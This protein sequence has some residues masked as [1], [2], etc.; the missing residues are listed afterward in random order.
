M[1]L[2][3]RRRHA[4]CGNVHDAGMF[5]THDPAFIYSDHISMVQYC[6]RTCQA[7]M[8]PFHK[9]FCGIRSLRDQSP[10]EHALYT[11][12]HQWLKVASPILLQ[13]ALWALNV[14][15]FGSSLTNRVWYIFAL[16]CLRLPTY[17]MLCPAYTYRWNRN[18][19]LPYFLMFLSLR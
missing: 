2:P 13:Y 5:L 19:H 3:A 6:S 10:L 4:N 1:A 15:E 18:T 16:Y 11:Q 8:W 7:E 17:S 9:M 14:A 12:S